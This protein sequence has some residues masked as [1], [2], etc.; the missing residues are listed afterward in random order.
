MLFFLEISTRALNRP[1]VELEIENNFNNL[2]TLN[3]LRY[4]TNDSLKWKT[5]FNGSITA[6]AYSTVHIVCVTSERLVYFLTQANGTHMCSPIIIDDHVTLLKC[7][8]YFTACL[9]CNGSLYLWKYD[10]CMA[11]TICTLINGQSC[12][13]VLKGKQHLS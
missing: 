7:N 1:H 13:A 12:L 6:V 11:S 8:Q 2:K 5:I 9:T 3:Y 10:S 4:K